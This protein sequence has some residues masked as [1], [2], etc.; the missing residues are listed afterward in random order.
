[1][2]DYFPQSDF[3]KTTPPC[4]KENIHPETLRKFNQAREIAGIPFDPTSAARTEKYEKEKGRPGT[5]SHVV[6]NTKKCRA[7]DIRISSNSDRWII[8]NALLEAGFTRIG[9]ASG[10][11]HAD[12]DPDKVQNVIWT[13]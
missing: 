6:S 8:L 9:I 11:I 1:M 4:R 5:S 2:I 7:M 12:D 10:F 13:Y 3:D